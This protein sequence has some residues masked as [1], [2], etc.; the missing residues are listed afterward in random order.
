MDMYEKRVRLRE[1]LAAPECTPL[2][3][4]YD[5]LRACL[6]GLNLRRLGLASD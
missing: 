5:L 6:S 1:L 4:A 3:G 2:M